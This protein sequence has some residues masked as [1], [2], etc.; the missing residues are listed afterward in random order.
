MEF[1]NVTAS[2]QANVY[3]DGKVI[4]HSLK[5]ETGE[6]KTL[7]IIF[8]GSYHFDTAAAE[9]MEITAGSCSVTL[10]GQDATTSYAAGSHFDVAANSGFTI[11][12]GEG[13]CQYVC[14]FL[15]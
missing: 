4:S 3:F 1:K 13:Q 10:D 14:S 9:R 2:A 15:S 8:A 12:V 7:G 6:E 5:T 11:A